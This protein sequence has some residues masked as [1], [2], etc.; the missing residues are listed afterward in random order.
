MVKFTR[1]A[2]TLKRKEEKRIVSVTVKLLVS[3]CKGRFR[4]TDIM[5]QEGGNLTG[6]LPENKIMLEKLKDGEKLIAPVFFNGIIRESATIIYPNTGTETA[7]LD[8][9]LYPQQDIEKGQISVSHRYDAQKAVFMED[10]QG[11]DTLALLSSQRKCLKNGIETA[12]RGFFQYSA[13]GD[14]KHEIFLGEGKRANI[15][16][17]LQEM[18]ESGVKIE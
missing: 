8:V 12:K 1:F 16:V 7:G 10:V 3:D 13:S 14:N 9:Y 17:E 6:Y 15:L 5:F 4:F 18:A 11:S 2:E